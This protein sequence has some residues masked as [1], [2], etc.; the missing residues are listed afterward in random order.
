MAPSARLGRSDDRI[1]AFL[2]QLAAKTPTPG[3]GS[4]AGLSAALGAA[5]L[6]M[7]AGYTTG[8][9]FADVEEEMGQLADQLGELR[10]Q[11]MASMQADEDA[12][13]DVGAAYALPRQSDEDRARRTAAVEA[14]LLGAAGPPREVGRI[15][16]R[17]LPIASVLAAKG[18]RNVVS[19]VG[20]GAAC[21]RAALDSAL[22]NV[23][24]NAAHLTDPGQKAELEEAVAAMDRDRASLDA[25]IEQVRGRVAADPRRDR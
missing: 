16:A 1:G 2:D 11:A 12:F 5:L 3:G 13:A 22:L 17:L 10:Q 20:A 4:A 15:C 23:A 18:N 21:A 8:A 19:D 24:V 14:A 25:V 6:A 9:R 7:V